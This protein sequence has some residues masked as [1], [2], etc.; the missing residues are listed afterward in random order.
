MAVKTVMREVG[1]FLEGAGIAI[2]LRAGE[3]WGW[4]VFV[5]GGALMVCAVLLRAYENKGRL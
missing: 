1:C 4:A 3:R 2:S 5:L